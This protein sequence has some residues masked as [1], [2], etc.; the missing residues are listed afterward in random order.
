MSLTEVPTAPIS[1]DEEVRLR[2]L[3][4]ARIAAAL[5]AMLMPTGVVME[6]LSVPS[7]V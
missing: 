7:D 4:G 2:N 3:R 6:Y 5:A 1:F